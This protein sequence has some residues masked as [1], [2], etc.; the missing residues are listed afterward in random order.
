MKVGDVVLYEG[1]ENIDR[2]GDR[3]KVV[4]LFPGKNKPVSI[5]FLD[6]H[7]LLTS[8]DHLTVVSE[9]NP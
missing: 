6:G 4:S 3:A 1:P 9:T 2:N 7:T 8:G 5:E